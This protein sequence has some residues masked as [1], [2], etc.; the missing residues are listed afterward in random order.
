MLCLP[1]S[2]QKSLLKA[3]LYTDLSEGYQQL[4]IWQNSVDI[5]KHIPKSEIR[6][7][8][9]IWCKYRTQ[10]A[11]SP[12]NDRF[13]GLYKKS[14]Y[15]NSL[16]FRQLKQIIDVFDRAGFEYAFTKGVALHYY[17]YSNSGSR[18]MN[19][20]DILVA[21]KN[22]IPAINRLFG[23]GYAFKDTT[24][25]MDMYIKGQAHACTLKHNSLKDID[26]H[27]YPARLHN[28]K[29]TNDFFLEDA[30]RCDF[31]GLSI[32]LL[33]P[34][35]LCLFMLVNYQFSE[36]WHWIA[37]V[38]MLHEKYSISLVKL[39]QLVKETG[40]YSFTYYQLLFLWN[41]FRIGNPEELNFYLNQPHLVIDK[42]AVES[43]STYD[44]KAIIVRVAAIN[45]LCQR[46]RIGAKLLFHV[47]KW[48]YEQARGTPYQKLLGRSINMVKLI[49]NF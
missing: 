10:L 13:G 19:D 27:Y 48:I 42:Y 24:Y 35:K 28:R 39:R 32:Q 45:G 12:F 36:E 34:E 26:L 6:L 49:R 37:D 3:A 40:L 9:M 21:Q 41:E 15:N 47:V 1:N 17:L 16:L 31:K 5:H 7:I 38:V 2:T 4:L 18:P 43:K 11:E 22:F 46:K 33:S 8:P 20:I 14:F 30:Q 44:L 23:I 25:T 29:L